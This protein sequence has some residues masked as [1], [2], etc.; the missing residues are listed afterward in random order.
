MPH[1]TIIRLSGVA[2]NPANGFPA[3]PLGFLPEIY[4][5][6]KAFDTINQRYFDRQQ[7]LFPAVFEGF[8]QLLA[9]AEKSVGIYNDAL[10]V[11]IEHPERLLG[12]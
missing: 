9:L 4:T 7:P 3:R 2:R 6:R 11:D 1:K 10:A 12:E 5:L 8:D